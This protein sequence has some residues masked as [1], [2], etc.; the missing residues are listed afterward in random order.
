MTWSTIQQL[1]RILAYTAGAYFLGD[2]IANGEAF[3]AAIG[4]LVNVGAFAWWLLFE[5]NRVS[6]P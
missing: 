1:I 2:G 3:Q 4:G 5:R 6:Q